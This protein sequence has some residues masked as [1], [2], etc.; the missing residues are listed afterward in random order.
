MIATRVLKCTCSTNRIQP[1]MRT[2]NCRPQCNFVQMSLMNMR[3]WQ[4]HRNIETHAHSHS[5]HRQGRGRKR[6][7]VSIHPSIHPYASRDRWMDGWLN[8]I[9]AIFAIDIYIYAVCIYLLIA[10]NRFAIAVPAIMQLLFLVLLVH[11]CVC[12]LFLLFCICFGVHFDSIHFLN[13]HKS[14]VNCH[15]MVI[16]ENHTKTSRMQMLV[17]C[18]ARHSMNKT[19]KCQRA[20]VARKPTLIQNIKCVYASIPRL[21]ISKSNRASA[22]ATNT[23]WLLNFMKRERY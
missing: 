2:K 6:D 19:K 9:V 22:F 23:W 8:G 18:M 7:R 10:H 20:I 12:A 21:T 4:E 13:K 17:V 11:E 15:A 5:K 16:I 1:D 14:Y 3:W